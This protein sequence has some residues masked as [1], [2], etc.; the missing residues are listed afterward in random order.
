MFKSF[1][2]IFTVIWLWISIIVTSSKIAEMIVAS[3]NNSAMKNTAIS[4]KLKYPR[5]VV[6]FFWTI[7]FILIMLILKN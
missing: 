1:L 4:S 6:A 7:W 5:N 3:I 2:I